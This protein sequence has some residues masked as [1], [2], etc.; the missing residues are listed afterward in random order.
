MTADPASI[1]KFLDALSSQSGNLLHAI[2]EAA[3]AAF[4]DEFIRT[5]RGVAVRG[6]GTTP[7]MAV[8]EMLGISGGDAEVVFTHLPSEPAVLAAYLRPRVVEGTVEK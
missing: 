1:I 3:V 5:P 8:L 4:P 7:V 6:G 2:E